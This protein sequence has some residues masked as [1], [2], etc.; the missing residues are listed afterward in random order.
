MVWCVTH[1]GCV[2][3][4]VSWG[5]KENEMIETKKFSKRIALALITC[6]IACMG[7]FALTGCE[8]DE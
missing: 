4:C 6:L 8:S 3:V 1:A 7:M 5:R 2:I